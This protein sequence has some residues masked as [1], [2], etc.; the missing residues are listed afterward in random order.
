MNTE[1]VNIER[2]KKAWIEMGMALNMKTANDDAENV[3]NN[4]TT[5]EKLHDRY[6]NIGISDICGAIIMLP[7]L[8]YAGF[9]PETYRL[10]VSISFVVLLLSLAAFI[11]WMWHG[12]GKID[13]L[14][15]TVTQVSEMALH[16]KKCHMRFVMVGLPLAFSWIGFFIY[17]V[18]SNS[19]FSVIPG[20]IVGGIAGSIIGIRAFSQFMSDYKHL[21]E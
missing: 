18:A 5:L 2:L 1:N 7:I 13:P 4:Q 9:L 19:E 17:A 11:F 15:M 10:S 21:S 14:T 20:I 12:V 6:R 8:L 16:Y 3:M